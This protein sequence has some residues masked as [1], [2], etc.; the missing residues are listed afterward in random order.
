MLPG[1]LTSDTDLVAEMLATEMA[2]AGPRSDE[3]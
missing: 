2:A 3:R 1:A